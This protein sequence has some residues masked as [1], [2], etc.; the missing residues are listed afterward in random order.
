MN[1]ENQGEILNDDTGESE[2]L[3]KERML[4][5]ARRLAEKQ[6]EIVDDPNRIFKFRPGDRVIADYLGH[7]ER[8]WVVL[9]VDEVNGTAELEREAAK[10]SPIAEKAS[11]YAPSVSLRD[12]TVA[13][14]SEAPERIGEF[15]A[16]DAG[17]EGKSNSG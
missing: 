15:E 4:A 13:I 17:I 8:N 12:L 1:Y 5:E 9:S 7:S 10:Q 11:T 2:R 3:K 6:S 16:R 14:A